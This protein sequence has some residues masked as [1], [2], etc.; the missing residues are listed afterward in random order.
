MSY[1]ELVQAYFER[2][3]ALQWYWTVLVFVIGGVLGFSTFRQQRSTLTTLLV[4]LLFAGFSYK[5]LGA[6]ETTAAQQQAF[7]TAMKESPATGANA[8]DVE[9]LRSKLE[10]TLPEYDAA[11]TRTFHIG[12]ALLTIAFLWVREARRKK[13]D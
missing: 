7:R 1:T 6:I 9:R 3:V 8:A 5:N 10:S 4:T 11:G 13:A 12:C 2:A